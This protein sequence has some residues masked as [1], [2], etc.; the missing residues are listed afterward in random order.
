MRLVLLILGRALA[1]IGLVG[2]VASLLIAKFMPL[3]TV[4]ALCKGRTE[5]YPE[6]VFL[7][8]TFPFFVKVMA[9][10]VGIL[11]VRRVFLW[12]RPRR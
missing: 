2:A 12:I 5:C 3:S 6:V 4:Q 8:I 11:I 9:V 10:G 7:F 1:L